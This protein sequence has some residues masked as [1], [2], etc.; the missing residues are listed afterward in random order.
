[1]LGEF[2]FADAVSVPAESHILPSLEGIGLLVIF[3]ASRQLICL[4]F[5]NR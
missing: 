4:S 2:P 5:S 3:G 1:M